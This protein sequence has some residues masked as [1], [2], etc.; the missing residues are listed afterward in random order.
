MFRTILICR[1]KRQVDIGLRHRAQLFFGLFTGFLQTLQRHRVFPKID[2]IFFFEFVSNVVNEYLIK[3]IASQ[4]G[5]ATG[6]NDFENFHAFVVVQFQDG[7][8]ERT[9]TKIENDDLLLVVRL[10][11]TVCHGGSGRFV[12]DTSNFQTSNLA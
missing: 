4:V 12:D 3:I 6:A 8:V 10:V 2:C 11:Q 7:N 5:I 1:D 9:T